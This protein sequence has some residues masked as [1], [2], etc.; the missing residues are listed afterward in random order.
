MNA[1][2][3]IQDGKLDVFFRPVFS[4]KQKSLAGYE[5]FCRAP[6]GREDGDD[7]GR[8]AAREGL[9]LEMDRLRRKASLEGFKNACAPTD[10][11]LFLNFS[12]EIVDQGVVGSNRLFDLVMSLGLAPHNIVIGIN[13][14]GAEDTASL[15]KFI[16]THKG[17]GFLIALDRIGAGHSNL[18][19]ISLARP[20]ILK[21][22]PSLVRGIHRDHYHRE[23]LRS[24]TQ[25]SKKLGALVAAD[26]VTEEEELLALLELGVDMVQG[27]YFGETRE[28]GRAA[29]RRWEEKLGG[30]AAKSKNFLVEKTRREKALHS[31][32]NALLGDVLRELSKA[33]PEEFDAALNAWV[34][35]HPS[36][37][38]V[39]VL[40]E[41]GTQISET[42][43]PPGRPFKQN[44]LFR[45]AR[46]GADHS[47]KDYYYLLTD[48]FVNRFRTEPY[49]SLASGNLCVTLSGLFRDARSRQ[50]VLC[51]D[52][53]TSP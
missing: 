53:P 1:R 2:Q 30:V 4:V 29:E 49:I 38:C 36:V 24:F 42:V 27:P 5:A 43:A 18:N 35:R 16:E 3:I 44:G 25:L 22:D 14:S 31:E 34:R 8:M 46:K 10:L 7:L 19:R 21:M 48:T 26:G 39:Y 50:Y 11:I 20:D 17:H 9:A 15:K 13:E 47:F 37:E 32:Q 12:S 23:I 41:E 33:V 52:A 51:L 45:P 40:D 6:S 28:I